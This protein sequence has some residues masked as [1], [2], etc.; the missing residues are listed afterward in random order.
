[1][2]CSDQREFLAWDEVQIGSTRAFLNSMIKT[3]TKLNHTRVLGPEVASLLPNQVSSVVQAVRWLRNTRPL[4]NQTRY[5]VDQKQFG[6]RES[7]TT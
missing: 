7:L 5:A 2:G 1:M 3:S 4:S 6:A